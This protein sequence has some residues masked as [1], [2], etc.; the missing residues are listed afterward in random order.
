MSGTTAV[1]LPP[2]EG[3]LSPIARAAAALLMLGTATLL[4][5][6]GAIHPGWLLALAGAISFVGLI[7]A[8]LLEARTAVVLLVPLV[9]LAGMALAFVWP[10]AT[11][12]GAVMI[13]MAGLLRR[14]PVH[15]LLTALLLSAFE[16]ALKLRLAIEGTP[17]P[18]TIGALAID[19][20]LFSAIAGLLI[21]DRAATLRAVWVNLTRFE[22]GASGLLVFWLAVSVLQTAQS[23]DVVAGFRAFASARLMSLRR[24]PDC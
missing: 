19:F 4:G 7:L 20:S 21:R 5:L 18:R 6:A 1:G 14:A 24:W 23:G 11:I 9:A 17:S 10:T 22:R 3:R 2:P 16:G 15:A 12:L 13:V 8:L